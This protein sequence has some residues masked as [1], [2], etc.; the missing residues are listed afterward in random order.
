MDASGSAAGTFTLTEALRAHARASPERVA[1]IAAD[2][3]GGLTYAD[4]DAGS[5]RLAQLLLEHGVGAR[6]RVPHLDRNDPAAAL[7][8]LAAAKVGAALVPLNWRLAEPELAAL[9]V[10]CDAKLLFAGPH[11]I[12]QARRLAGADSRETIALEI[13]AGV[14]SPASGH[15][16]DDPRRDGDEDAVVLQLYTSG[17]T[18]MPKGVQTTN[19]NLARLT[20]GL[21][22][23]WTVD[24]A[25]RCLVAM[26]VFHIG[27]MGWLIVGLVS[28][29]TNVL[30]PAIDP[31]GLLDTMESQ[32][33][34]NA[35][36]VPTVL[37]ML[38]DVPG[39][40]QRDWAALRCIG[41][42]ASPIT[43]TTLTRALQT[44]GCPFFQVYGM[45][46]TTGAI[47]QL[48]AADHDP[49]GPR[50][51]LLRSAGRA[52]PWMELQIVE[53]GTDRALERNRIGEVRVRG[54]SVTPGYFRNEAETAAALASDGWLATGDGG[55][56][57]DDGYLF[58]TDRI[59]DM[60]VSGAEN[61][62]PVEVEEVIATHPA[63][64]EVAVFG[65]TDERWGEIV[66]AAVVTGDGEPPDAEQLI[67]FARSRLAGYK[68]P[69]RIHHLAEL[70][71]T[72]SG[73]VSKRELRETFG[74]Q[75]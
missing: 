35:F 10:D 21:R 61:V 22:E 54:D 48:D 19:R 65:V 8:L 26:P 16:P 46:E 69:R 74:S 30:V 70:P 59:K 2:D 63:I 71:K 53:P 58:L 3:G 17:T 73:K 39:S 20:S 66:C 52:Y 64:A 68:L 42:G 13:G 38:C 56:L 34:T 45:T 60:I 55:Y 75:S 62:Y 37:Q 51:Y 72:G 29:A 28:G 12:E 23:Y 7:L 1:A 33:I 14:P 31:R 11:F 18:G 57:D 36:V 15:A 49:G 25:S 4:L 9:V 40:G 43:T 41:Y 27:G 6:D 67:A 32:R 24:D 47:V 5:S 44:F 50:E